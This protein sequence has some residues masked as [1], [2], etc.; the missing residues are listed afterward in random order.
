MCASP[1]AKMDISPNVQKDPEFF[2]DIFACLPL[3]KVAVIEKEKKIELQV[4]FL[5]VYKTEIPERVPSNSIQRITEMVEIS[6]S[7]KR[8]F[9]GGGVDALN[10]DISFL[11]HVWY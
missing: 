8:H 5:N 7:Y 11:V 3:H 6:N 4:L 10:F 1:F 2:P 9:F